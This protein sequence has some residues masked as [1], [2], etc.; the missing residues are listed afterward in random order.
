MPHLMADERDLAQGGILVMDDDPVASLA[1]VD[2]VVH[3]HDEV[4]ER[5]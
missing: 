2:A 1:G 5:A 3:E 4:A